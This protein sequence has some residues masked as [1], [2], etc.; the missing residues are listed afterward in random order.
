MTKKS[1]TGI[2]AVLFIGL[3]NFS[4]AQSKLSKWQF[5]LQGGVNVYMGDLTPEPAGAYKTL[6]PAL[7]LYAA[8][9]LSPSFM[10]RG[11]LLLSAL[12]ADESR[13][14]KPEW[15]RQRNFSFSTPVTELSGLLVWNIFKNN[16]NYLDR[17]LSPY[18]MGG[19][20]V[21]FMRVRR[22]A[23]RMDPVIFDD[24]SEVRTGLAQDL[25]VAPPRTQLVLPFGAGV[26]Y[27]ISPR[28][29]LTAE[30]NFRYTFSDYID[31]FSQAANPDKKDYYYTHTLG[32]VV[33]M[34]NDG[35]S[36][37]GGRGKTGCP[38][39]AL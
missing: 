20:G 37:R 10:L 9:V 15:R 24:G 29:S 13:Y 4:Q 19:A 35:S 5:G 14:S 22:D 36:S 7:V 30:T 32:V 21:G 6:K 17:K 25:A 2:V 34:G 12:R 31:G 38:A 8:R 28:V 23:S 39:V 26:E 1:K 16:D 33:K 3:V 18:L 11:N 27:M